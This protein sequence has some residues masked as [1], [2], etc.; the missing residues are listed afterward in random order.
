[1][2]P[3]APARARW[4]WRWRE[5][6]GG[7]IVS[8]D[9]AQVYRGMDVG[10]AK[11]DAAT[12]A[13]VPHH[14][15]DVIDPTEAYSAARFRADALAAIAG[16]RGARPRAAAGRRHDALLQGADRRAVGAA[17]GR[18]R[19]SRAAL[20]ARAAARAGRRCTPS[21][22]ASIP[23]GGAAGAQRRAAD[24][25]RARGVR[26]DR[27]A[28]VGA[29]GRADGRRTRWGRRSRSRCCRPTARALHAAI[30]ARFDAM[31]ARRA[32]RRAARAART[33]T[34]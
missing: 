23:D 22:R 5:S 8:V 2:G 7:E 33:R 11:P 26:A 17:A 14:L 24:P 28:A 1:M 4:R 6:F 31:L 25:A 21:S 18:S 10:T 20:D 19:R 9:S 32:G 30:A 34:R 15:V 12:R 13:R 3:T 29:A 16:I 27:P